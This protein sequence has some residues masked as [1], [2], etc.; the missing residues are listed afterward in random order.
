MPDKIS[1]DPVR[2]KQVLWNLL[3]NA[4]KFTE[5][6][7]VTLR[8]SYSGNK[9]VFEVEDTGIG[10]SILDRKKLFK[11]FSQA[12]TTMTRRFGG[13]GLGLV[14]SKKL[15]VLLGGELKLVK[16]KIGAG[17]LFAFSVQDFVTNKDS[18]HKD[19]PKIDAGQSINYIN[20]NSTRLNGIRI[21]V[22]DDSPDN[23][24]LME[25]LLT[26]HHA[27]IAFASDGK[28]AV[29]KA[30]HESFDI[31]LMDIQMPVMDGY[32]ATQKLREMGYRKPVIALTA[33]AMNEVRQQCLDVGCTDWASKPIDAENLLAK[34]IHHLQRK[35]SEAPQPDSN[36]RFR[37]LGN[38]EG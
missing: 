20:R 10:I 31:I 33:H 1:S 16:S 37:V 27:R 24:L 8:V 25:H 19:S 6:G 5:H 30:L 7:G 28:E 9:V 2:L 32:T 26:K 29:E 22:V 11:P 15:C 3:G 36:K 35:T 12:D 21:L 23:Q 14:L 18:V 38:A 34:I 17:S 4:I 13:T